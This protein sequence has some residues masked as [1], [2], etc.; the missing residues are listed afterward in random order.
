[1]RTASH[2]TLPLL[3]DPVRVARALVAPPLLPPSVD[4]G[5]ISAALLADSSALLIAAI[6]ECAAAEPRAERHR[7]CGYLATS[8]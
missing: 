1:M 7:G 3:A 4:D 2:W 8:G 5:W 6:E